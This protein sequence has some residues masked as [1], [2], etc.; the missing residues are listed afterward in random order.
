[1]IIYYWKMSGLRVKGRGGR[2]KKKSVWIPA[3]AGMVLFL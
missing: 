2:G 1:M 3:F